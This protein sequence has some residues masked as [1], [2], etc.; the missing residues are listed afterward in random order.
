MSQVVQF[1]R[2]TLPTVPQPVV[3]EAFLKVVL[4]ALCV[5]VWGWGERVGVVLTGVPHFIKKT[6][7]LPIIPVAE[8]VSM[9]DEEVVKSGVRIK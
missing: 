1:P 8:F 6:S 7:G 4:P 9:K 3:E 5:C 2:F